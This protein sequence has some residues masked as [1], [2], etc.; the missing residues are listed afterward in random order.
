MVPPMIVENGVAPKMP[1]D[2]REKRQSALGFLAPLSIPGVE[3]DS[4]DIE[5]PE[6]QAS[7]WAY[8]GVLASAPSIIA[9]PLF[10]YT[11]F[12]QRE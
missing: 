9:V 1:I 3:P 6:R 7:L 8:S 5:E 11:L 4:P 10:L 2:T 12:I